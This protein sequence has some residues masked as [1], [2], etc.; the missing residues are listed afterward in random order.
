MPDVLV[1]DSLAASGDAGEPR[2]RWS[3]GKILAVVCVVGLTAMW[4]YALSGVAG[5]DVAGRLDDK[6]FGPRAEP[7]CNEAMA[8]VDGLPKGFETPEP[9]DRADVIDEGTAR[10]RTMVAELEALPR[11]DG[12]DASMISQ[13]LV[14]WTTFL[15]NRDDF[16]SRLRTDRNARFYVTQREEDKRQITA[17]LDRFAGINN[18]PSC[19]TPGDVG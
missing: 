7:V 10:L 18:M 14:D 5:R 19:E 1:D 2:R 13:W 3:V 17:A 11:P 12:D 15:D 8:V 9:T 16:T 4:A 6:T